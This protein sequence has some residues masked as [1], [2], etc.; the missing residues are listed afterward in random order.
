MYQLYMGATR[1]PVAPEQI[2]TKINGQ[3][4]TIT[5]INEGEV[6]VLKSP[7]LTDISF[8]LLLPAVDYSF[9]FHEAGGTI[10]HY[11]T[12]LEQ[13][14]QSDKPFKFKVIRTYPNGKKLYNTSMKVSLEEY[15]L[16][17]KWSEGNDLKVSI[18]LKQYRNYGTKKIKIDKNGKY[19]K[20]SK[21][22]AYQECKTYKIA[23][24]DTMALISRKCYGSGSK[25]NI[26]KIVASNKKVLN[27]MMP[28]KKGSIRTWDGKTLKQGVTLTI[29]RGS[30]TFVTGA[31]IGGTK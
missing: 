8:D 21:I 22:R 20:D 11:L 31:I 13:L 5:L 9:A 14:K 29:P 17:E 1:F 25:K 2:T 16:D 4:T 3:N 6:N 7:G 23:K 27:N 28:K 10:K 24:G 15:S 19:Y 12:V 18:S 30:V 26:D